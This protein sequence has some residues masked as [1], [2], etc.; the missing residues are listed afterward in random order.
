MDFQAVAQQLRKPDGD[1]GRR[2]GKKMNEGN[3]WIY[4]YTLDALNLEP[5]Q[6]VLEIG[7]GNGAF[8]KDL[9]AKGNSIKYLD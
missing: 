3:L 1:I 7:M 9:M 6:H 2:V 5:N 8:V 4:K